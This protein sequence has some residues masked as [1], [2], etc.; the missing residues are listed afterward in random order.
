MC[1]TN[2]EQT[3]RTWNMAFPFASWWRFTNNCLPNIKAHECDEGC[4]ENIYRVTNVWHSHRAVA[5]F[6]Q[7]DC[8][9]CVQ[10]VR[11]TNSW[12][13]HAPL[14]CGPA[15]LLLSTTQHNVQWFR[16]LVQLNQ[17]S[18]DLG[19]QW[20]HWFFKQGCFSAYLQE[21]KTVFVSDILASHSEFIQ[22]LEWR[23]P[24]WIYAPGQWTEIRHICCDRKSNHNIDPGNYQ[25]V[26]RWLAI[27][28]ASQ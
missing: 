22:S 18:E 25:P 4:V 24:K 8:N 20:M 17:G 9:A 11:C 19:S 7:V 2:S 6:Q 10:H 28:S 26:N 23:Q 13:H 21:K 5:S 15:V 27:K 16:L 3:I 1:S 14:L 12:E